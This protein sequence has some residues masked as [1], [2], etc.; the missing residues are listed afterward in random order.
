VRQYVTCRQTSPRWSQA[1][2]MAFACA[3]PLV[4]STHSR[5][6]LHQEH[7]FTQPAAPNCWTMLT[8]NNQLCY[9]VDRWGGGG[10]GEVGGVGGRGKEGGR[11]V[12]V[13]RCLTGNPTDGGG[14]RVCRTLAVFIPAAL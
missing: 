13:K 8:R 7:C 4:L 9:K 1:G 3:Q 10:G 2:Q 12:C 6:S 14:C 11:V 5:H